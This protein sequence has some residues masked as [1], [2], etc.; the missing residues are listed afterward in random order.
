MN[1]MNEKLYREFIKAFAN[2][3]SAHDED[4]AD[5][6]DYDIDSPLFEYY[7]SRY[8][9]KEFESEDEMWRNF[10]ADFDEAFTTFF[11]GYI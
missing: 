1:E 9:R 7:N 5:I 2:F 4:I 6:L 11:K 3:I 10:W 8:S